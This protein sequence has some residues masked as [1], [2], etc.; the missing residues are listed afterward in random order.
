M[1]TITASSAGSV[2]DVAVQGL[3]ETDTSM[4]VAMDGSNSST[5][6]IHYWVLD[7]RD[8]GVCKLCYA[9]KQFKPTRPSNPT[10]HYSH[11]ALR[12]KHEI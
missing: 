4:M 12:A 5:Q 10:G 8:F 1:D 7:K 3:S 2:T 11:K 6:C 9:T